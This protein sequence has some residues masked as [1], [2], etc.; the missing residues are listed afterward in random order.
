LIGG[1]NLA[2]LKFYVLQVPFELEG[3]FGVLHFMHQ[4]LK[5]NGICVV[6]IA[7]GAGQVGFS[8]CCEDHAKTSP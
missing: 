7:E 2:S 3:D 5:R 6:V 8:D 1:N 4:R